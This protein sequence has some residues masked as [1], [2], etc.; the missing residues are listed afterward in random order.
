M[1]FLLDASPD[2]TDSS[3]DVNLAEGHLVLT[4]AKGIFIQL[5][6]TESVAWRR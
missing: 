6:F 1:V 5:L 2:Y 4:I 3:P